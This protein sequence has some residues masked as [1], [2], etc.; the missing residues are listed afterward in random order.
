MAASQASELADK[1]DMQIRL[2]ADR[3]LRAITLRRQAQVGVAASTALS[4]V[5]AAR[6]DLLSPDLAAITRLL[7]VSAIRDWL[8]EKANEPEHDDETLA[9]EA[10]RQLPL[11]QIDQL[12]TGQHDLLRA[13][14]RQYSWQQQ[15]LRLQEEDAAAGAQLLTAFAEMTG[16][17]AA[18]RDALGA[19]ATATQMETVLSLIRDQVL[20]RLS[21]AT[22]E[23][24]V[25]SGNFQ[26]AT[27]I[28]ESPVTIAWPAGTPYSPPLQPAPGPLPPGDIGDPHDGLVPSPHGD[29]L[30]GHFYKDLLPDEIRTEVITLVLEANVVPHGPNERA[31]FL[32]LCGLELFSRYLPLSGSDIEFVRA[33]VYSTERH[34]VLKHSGKD[35]LSLLLV[36]ISQEEITPPAIA[37]ELAII[38]KQYRPARK[39]VQNN[40]I[41]ASNA[42]PA[43]RR[44]V[45]LYLATLR[46][47]DLE[48]YAYY[49]EV[50][51]YPR[52]N[53]KYKGDHFRL[54]MWLTQEIELR[55][56]FRELVQMLKPTA[57]NQFES[58][59]M[60][61]TASSSEALYGNKSIQVSS[62]DR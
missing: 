41:Q 40:S 2:A 12:L 1:V 30:R 59:K 6:P 8:K 58:Y 29:N 54:A 16:D 24:Y 44:Q 56:K 11:D 34:G 17:L 3:V 10:E 35:A 48:A 33:L 26:G 18:I 21:E 36:Y 49:F 52:Q 25:L 51:D 27:L 22:R 46:P 7:A 42:T 19:V 15:M 57:P 23:R 47:L 20:P 32:G 28:I 37:K 61:D 38:M 39:V 31:T 45:H 4:I 50:N 43:E 55:G 5:S 9:A 13:L 60:P 62:T 53:Q 14:T